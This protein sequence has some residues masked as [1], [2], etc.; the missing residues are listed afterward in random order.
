MEGCTGWCWIGGLWEGEWKAIE[1]RLRGNN[2]E[3]LSCCLPTA[4]ETFFIQED[5]NLQT[6]RIYF[7]E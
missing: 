4:L 3:G 7:S 1:E 5:R 2:G 6:I